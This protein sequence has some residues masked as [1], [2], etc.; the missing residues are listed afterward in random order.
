MSLCT[1]YNVHLTRLIYIHEY[2]YIYLCVHKKSQHIRP[3]SVCAYVR[4]H[5]IRKRGGIGIFEIPITLK[6][7][8]PEAFVRARRG[9]D[10]Y[11]GKIGHFYGF[12]AIIAETNRLIK[13]THEK[14]VV[15][16]WTGAFP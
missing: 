1:H 14:T 9:T 6:R 7:H 2:I 11:A 12:R 15:R 3:R 13:T 10:E 8:Y 4:A 5:V 16:R